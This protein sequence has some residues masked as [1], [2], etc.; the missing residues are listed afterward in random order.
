MHSFI[1]SFRVR[2]VVE[3]VKGYR[4]EPGSFPGFD[5]SKEQRQKEAAARK[6]R[7]ESKRKDF[8]ARMVRKAKREGLDPNAYL[9]GQ[10]P[11][12]IA[13]VRAI[14]TK[15]GVGTGRQSQQSQQSQQQQS[16]QQQSQQQQSQQQQSQQQQSQQQQSQQ[17]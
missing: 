7:E 13:D 10:D 15:L 16:Q 14:Q 4:D 1:R 2:R 11:P 6:K 9:E 17:A 8:E 5:P 3:L 12:S